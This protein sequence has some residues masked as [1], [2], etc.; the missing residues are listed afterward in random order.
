LEW[1]AAHVIRAGNIVPSLSVQP[2]PSIED[3]IQ[4]EKPTPGG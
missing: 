2:G 1:R 4:W 3:L